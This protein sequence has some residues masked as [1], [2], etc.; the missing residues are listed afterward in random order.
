MV[1][2]IL[3]QRS[4]E[5]KVTG[6][7]STKEGVT[8]HQNCLLYS[9]GLF[10][11][12]TPDFDDLFGFSATDVLSE[13]RRG[14]K[15][16]CNKC[17]K[18][19]A[20]V[21]C[22]I[23]TC[24]KSYHYPCAIQAKAQTFEDQ[25]NESFGLY[26]F[27]CQKTKSRTSSEMALSD[28]DLPSTSTRNPKRKLS[29]NDREEEIRAPRHS[30]RIMS[31]ESTDSDQTDAGENTGLISPLQ[32]DLDENTNSQELLNRNL[33]VIATVTVQQKESQD[34]TE[35]AVTEL[36]PSNSEQSYLLQ[37]EP[38][39]VLMDPSYFWSNCTSSG[40]AQAI[41][42]NFIQEM[43]DIFTRITSG[44]ASTQDCDVALK[45]MMASGKLGE[46]VAKQQKDLQ[47]KLTELQQAA[48]ALD[49]AALFLP[50]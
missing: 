31:I 42:T 3:C 44:Q 33:P 41:F 28:E 5:N 43:T 39:G 46:L 48:T 13:H 15:L 36:Q 49:K 19:G 11:R 22:E 50:K 18:K 6:V 8:A 2:C 24:R 29:F 16:T 23:S 21:G 17:K 38:N 45:V 20:T 4:E 35:D 26:C 30:R 25:F 37:V 7:L 32:S 9:S 47:K 14:L 10:C 27:G 1:S 34:T 40:C 12:N